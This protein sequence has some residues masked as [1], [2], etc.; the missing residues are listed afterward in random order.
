MKPIEWP[1]E[2][3]PARLW[4]LEGAD[5]DSLDRLFDRI[6]DFES[7]FWPRGSADAVGMFLNVPA[8]K[9]AEDKLLV[10]IWDQASLVGVLDCIPQYPDDETWTVGMLAVSSAR[11]RE[12]LGSQVLAWLESEAARNGG[13][14]LQVKVRDQN[15]GGRRFLTN[16]GFSSTR[17]TTDDS[18]VLRK[19]IS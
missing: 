12:G 5:G 4:L 15:L 11:R 13:T 9:T 3:G 14:S 18:T 2:I 6:D 10:G 7:A 17:M 1:V 19:P 16:R 8:N